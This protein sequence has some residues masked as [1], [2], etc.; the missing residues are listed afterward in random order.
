MANNVA[1]IALNE[2]RAVL[3]HKSGQI[4]FSVVKNI[5][6]SLHDKEVS[7]LE[8]ERQVKL[9]EFAAWILSGNFR[10]RYFEQ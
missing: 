9:S 3:Q 4:D 1:D 2:R 6:K 7:L 10:R 8:R 5:R